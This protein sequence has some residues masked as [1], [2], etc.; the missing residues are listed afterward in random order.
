MK[1]LIVDDDGLIRDSLKILFET[2]EGWVART[3]GNG[4]S[5]LE[6]CKEEQPD[7]VLM[8]IRMPVFDGVE[9]TRKIK[10]EF[11]DVKIIMLTTFTDDGYISSA[12]NA[13]A[14]GYLLKSTPADG[15]I[16]RLRAVEKG[17][18]VFDKG[19]KLNVGRDVS[20]VSPQSSFP[21]LT[22]RE[23]E[24]LSLVATGLSNNEIAAKLFLSQGTVRNA[25]SAIL[26]KLDLRD[27]TQLAVCYWR[28]ISS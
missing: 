28:N 26:E 4:A 9:A 2:K 11:P 27:R 18:L 16:E 19:V 14:E 6:M 22:E 12:I 17:A 13:G 1:L 21:Q 23:N 3:A 25:V 8:D 20:G 24:V 10:A 15:I 7:I 5:A